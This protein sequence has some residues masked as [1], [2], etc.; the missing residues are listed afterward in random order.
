VTADP[1]EFSQVLERAACTDMKTWAFPTD[2]LTEWEARRPA[3]KTMPLLGTGSRGPA[4]IMISVLSAETRKMQKP[5]LAGIGAVIIG[6]G[7][8]KGYRL[9]K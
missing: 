9:S 2:F 1:V 4:T 7:L 5:Y 8:E 6:F 3:G